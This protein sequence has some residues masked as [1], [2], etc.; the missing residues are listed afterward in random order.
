MRP[1]SSFQVKVHDHTVKII[2]PLEMVTLY[3]LFHGGKHSFKCRYLTKNC[4]HDNTK[5]GK[6]VLFKLMI[7]QN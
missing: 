1:I 6:K 5:V 7:T 2:G 4:S 3:L